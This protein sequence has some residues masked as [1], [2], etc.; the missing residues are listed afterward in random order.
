[1]TIDAAKREFNRIDHIMPVEVTE[2]ESKECHWAQIVNFSAGGM[3]LESDIVFQPG[4]FVHIRVY[5]NNSEP[6]DTET[7]KD[8]K[9]AVK[10]CRKTAEAIAGSYRIGVQFLGESKR[11][12]WWMMKTTSLRWAGR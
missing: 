4:K 12:S 3:C 7:I 1:M 11:C 6:T 8:F 5:K 2:E 10:Y 9:A